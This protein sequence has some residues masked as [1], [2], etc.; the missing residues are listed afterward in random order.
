MYS[1]PGLLPEFVMCTKGCTLSVAISLSPE[2]T[3]KRLP[4]GGSVCLKRGTAFFG[5]LQKGTQESN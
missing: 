2:V 4:A 5:G 3:V 1:E